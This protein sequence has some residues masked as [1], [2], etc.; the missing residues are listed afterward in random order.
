[1][2]TSL[3]GLRSYCKRMEEGNKTRRKEK[4]EKER[5]RGE[6]REE[7]RQSNPD[8]QDTFH[9]VDDLRNIHSPAW[10]LRLALR[11]G[12]TFRVQVL[13]CSALNPGPICIHK[14]HK[15]YLL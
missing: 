3:I 14:H 13:L 9:A 15:H 11:I 12:L 5:G 7:E 8:T 4:R 2:L 6:E 1:M 10:N